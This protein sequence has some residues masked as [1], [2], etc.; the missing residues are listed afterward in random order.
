VLQLLLDPSIQSPRTGGTTYWL[1]PTR[2]NC[3]AKMGCVNVN[4]ADQNV[5]DEAAEAAIIWAIVVEVSIEC[6]HSLILFIVS[7]TSASA[8]TGQLNFDTFVGGP[9]VA[10]VAC[11]MGCRMHVCL[12]CSCC[13]KKLVKL[14]L[15]KME[16]IFRV[17]LFIFLNSK[18][19]KL[20]RSLMI[21]TR[22]GLRYSSALHRN[23]SIWEE[24]KNKKEI[25]LPQQIHSKLFV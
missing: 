25:L 4:C 21:K 9:L 5:H 8:P 22:N 12:V 7:L 19:K 15:R 16:I 20:A 6:C 3:R 18:V 17:L 23:R 13:A 1:F 10:F 24:E 2:Q 14:Q 11:G